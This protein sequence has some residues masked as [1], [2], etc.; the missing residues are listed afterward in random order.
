MQESNHHVGNLHSGVVDV[1]L[2]VHFPARKAQ[3][4]DEGIAKNGVAQVPDM[5][6]FIGIDA[7]MF[8]EHFAGG[9]IRGRRSICGRTASERKIG[10]ERRGQLGAAYANVDVPAAGHFKLLK[11]GN[12]ADPGDDLFGNLARRFAKLPRKFES[13]RQRILAKFDL[14]RL[15][16]DDVRDFQVVSAAQKLA[17]MIDQPAF[18]MSIQGCPLTYRR[19]SDSNK[20]VAGSEFDGGKSVPYDERSV[21]DRWSLVGSKKAVVGRWSLAS[22]AS[23]PSEFAESGFA[24]D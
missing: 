20:P 19:N 4:A 24:N 1:V 5:R 8:D 22:H 17:Q 15:L 13:D 7:G 16:D 6:C 21:V 10:G 3:Q 9:N 2:H 12:R 14:R 11:A 18:Q 23:S